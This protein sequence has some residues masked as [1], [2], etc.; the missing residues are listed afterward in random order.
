MIQRDFGVTDLRTARRKPNDC[1]HRLLTILAMNQNIQTVRCN[2][3]IGL[4]YDK[5]CSARTRFTAESSH[6]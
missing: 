2:T 6:Q 4:L 3:L 1:I 5:R